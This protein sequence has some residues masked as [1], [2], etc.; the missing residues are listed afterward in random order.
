MLCL[1]NLLINNTGYWIA[2]HHILLSF[3]CVQQGQSEKG[4]KPWEGV[5]KNLG[6]TF[7]QHLLGIY[8]VFWYFNLKLNNGN[9][10]ILVQVRERCNKEWGMFRGRMAEAEKKYYESMGITLPN[11]TSV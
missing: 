3:F 5:S 2:S 6:C 10:W 4:K 11:K 1:Y 7:L 8:C 9:K